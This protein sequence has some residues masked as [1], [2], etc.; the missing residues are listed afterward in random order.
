MNGMNPEVIKYLN[1]ANLPAGKAGRWHE[2]IY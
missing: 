2:D 1:E